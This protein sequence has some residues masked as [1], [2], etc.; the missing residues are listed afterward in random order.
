MAT[1][2]QRKLFE[3]LGLLNQAEPIN[4]FEILGLDPEFAK[5]LLKEDKNGGAVRL[6]ADGLY[7]V[8]S[9]RYYPDVQ[10]TGDA[11]RFRAINEASLRIKDATPAALTRWS[12]TERT[13][14]STT[15]DKYKAE[16]QIMA[17]R[18][19]VLLRQNIELA[20]HPLH[21]S[22]LDSAQGLLLH[23]SGSTLLLR[24]RPDEGVQINPGRISV[25]NETQR[26]AHLKTLANDFQ[27]FM[28]RHES[29]GL[30]PGSKIATYIDQRGRASILNPDLEFIMDISGP[31][32]EHRERHETLNDRARSADYWSRAEDPILYLTTLPEAGSK[33]EI[34]SQ[35]IEFPSRVVGRYQEVDLTWDISMEVAGSIS[36]QNFFNR[37]KHGKSVGA[38]ALRGSGM[39]E[40]MSRFSMIGTPEQRLI[41]GDAGYSPLL[42]PGKSLLLFDP[43]NNVPVITDAQI[44]GLVG[45]NS[46]AA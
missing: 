31:V 43:Y 25:L 32:Q 7:R 27:E 24:Q 21:F 1:R 36:E 22:Q 11:E 30:E 38:A 34:T 13:P 42:A 37:M 6:V 9:K 18:A 45:N 14:S 40:E 46:S 15:A 41:E 28:K 4:P 44:V 3:D 23:R 17:E 16:R 35:F 2:N 10:K 5:N 12:K 8:L 39:G 19:A 20:H 33:E 26:M 29:F